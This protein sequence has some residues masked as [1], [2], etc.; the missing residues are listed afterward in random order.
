MG[1]IAIETRNDILEV[2]VY[3]E[4]TLADYRRFE[5]TVSGRNVHSTPKHKLLFDVRTM[6][7]FTVDVAWEEIKFTRAHAHDFRRIAIVTSGQWAPWVSWVAG[8][9]SDAEVMLFEE[10]DAAEAWL[11]DEL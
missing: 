2:G 10:P 11:A 4:L 9:F 1:M 6:A 7:G 8:A 3:A 5:E